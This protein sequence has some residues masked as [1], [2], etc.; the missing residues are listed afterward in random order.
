MAGGRRLR[1]PVTL[2]LSGLEVRPKPHQAEILEELDAERT[3]HGRHRNLVVVATGTGRTVVA[4][5]DYSRLV[6]HPY[7]RDLSLLFVAH[8][9]RPR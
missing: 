8:L 1:D 3:L 6:Q 2:T 7:G 5:L 9:P 4:A